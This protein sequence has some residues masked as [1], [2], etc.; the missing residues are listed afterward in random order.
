M[1][2]SETLRAM[3]V[4]SDSSSRSLLAHTLRSAGYEVSAFDT[5]QAG[6]EA[7]EAAAY[8]VI[9]ADACLP[10][11]SGADFLAAVTTREVDVSVVMVI[12]ADSPLTGVECLNAGAMDYVTRPLVTEDLLARVGRAIERRTLLDERLR[13]EQ[14]VEA[15]TAQSS[16]DQRRLFLGAVESLASALEARDPH[17][18]G[19]S[20]RVADLSIALGLALGLSE[21]RREQLRIAALLHDIGKIGIPDKVLNKRGRLSGGERA[22]VQMHPMI[23]VRIL[24]PVLADSETVAIIQHHHERIDGSGYPD[25]LAGDDAPV[26]ARVLAAADSFDAMTS[27]RPYRAAYDRTQALD[28]MRRCAGTQ[29]DSEVVDAFHMMLRRRENGRNRER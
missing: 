14:R 22:Q 16:H 7:L 19:H 20:A 1:R 17:T 11:L 29:L 2:P 21:K 24:S 8:D 9:V 3:V 5:A 4:D 23:A 27:E 18:R 26:G 12:P 28:E 6:L 25:G 10:T 13:Y 15:Q